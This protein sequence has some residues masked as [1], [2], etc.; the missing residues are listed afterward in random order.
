VEFTHGDNTKMRL[1][2]ILGEAGYENPF[3]LGE[4]MIFVKQGF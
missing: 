4:D 3:D 1:K 2:K